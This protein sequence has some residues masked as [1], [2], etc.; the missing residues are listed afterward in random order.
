MGKS[1][2]FIYNGGNVARGN[3]GGGS[4]NV[5]NDVVPIQHVEL[6]VN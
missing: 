1:L 5:R 3:V 2:F 6:T 4:V